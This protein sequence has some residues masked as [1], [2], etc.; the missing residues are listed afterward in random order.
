MGVVGAVQNN[1]S[2]REESYSEAWGSPM[3]RWGGESSFEPSTYWIR[4]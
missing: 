1:N 3:R 2:L 4:E